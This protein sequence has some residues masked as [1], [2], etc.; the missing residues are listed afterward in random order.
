MEDNKIIYKEN[1]RS[2]LKKLFIAS[3][4]KAQERKK[5]STISTSYRFTGWTIYFYEWSDITRK[6]LEFKS[7]KEFT[8]FLKKSK[9]PFTYFDRQKLMFYK[10]NYVA[11]AKNKKDLKI[12]Y[13]YIS[14]RDALK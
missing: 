6:P 3:R 9:I 8:D 5:L 14:L 4:A 10:T 11:C 13:S 2:E 7:L 1:K 12:C